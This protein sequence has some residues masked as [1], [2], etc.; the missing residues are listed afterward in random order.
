MSD[1]ATTGS[2]GGGSEASMSRRT[3]PYVRSDD[4]S[5]LFSPGPSV[6]TLS[7]DCVQHSSSSGAVPEQQ[8][9]TT[10]S[11]FGPRR[12]AYAPRGRRKQATGPA[13]VALAAQHV[14]AL[15]MEDADRT[16]GIHCIDSGA[17]AT[18]QICRGYGIISP[19]FFL[20]TVTF[21]GICL[22]NGTMVRVLLKVHELTDQTK[23]TAVVVC[24]SVI[25]IWTLSVLLRTAFMDPGVVPRGNNA[26]RIS[27]LQTLVCI[28][29]Y[30]DLTIG[31]HV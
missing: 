28:L 26:G 16:G 3:S 24:W 7:F 17:T 15:Q 5:G 6:R 12:T 14:A 4:G 31:M 22:M 20:L 30:D 8:V 2:S 19:D 29:E 1:C 18:T 10:S 23:F 9:P 25:V 21:I 13:S 11:G 27:L